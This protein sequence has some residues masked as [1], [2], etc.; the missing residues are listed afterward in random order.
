MLP[1]FAVNFMM[2]HD[3]LNDGLWLMVFGDE[4]LVDRFRS[5]TQKH[6]N[7]SYS[8]IGDGSLPNE[9]PMSEDVG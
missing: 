6:G 2:V 8:R 3:L 1:C 7:H 5:V 9:S 4:R